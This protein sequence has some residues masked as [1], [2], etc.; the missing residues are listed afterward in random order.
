MKA[1]LA[2]SD[3]RLPGGFDKPEAGAAEPASAP[4][5]TRGEWG[6]VEMERVLQRQRQRSLRQPDAQPQLLLE[7]SGG[8]DGLAEQF[9]APPP[10][11]RPYGGDPELVVAADPFGP[12]A[13]AFRELRLQLGAK[14]LERTTK[15]A[16]AIVSPGRGDGKS[17]LAANLAASFGQLGGRTLLVDADLRTPRLHRLLGT[18]ECEGLSSVL[19]G[20]GGPSMIRQVAQVPGLYFLPAG[21]FQPNS[22]ELL[23]SPRFSLLLLEMLLAFDHVVLDTPADSWGADARVIAA[24]A[25]AALVVG[26]QGCSTLEALRTLLAKIG[27]RVEIA[28][29]VINQHQH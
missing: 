12:E 20:D 17:Y 2:G 21:P 7:R 23:Q 27:D 10:L 4:V 13:E 25:G 26:R 1:F 22:V 15:A 28:G 29:M 24:K 6:Q 8:A 18:P 19:R 11:P 14:A 9:C 16:L 3:H 5:R